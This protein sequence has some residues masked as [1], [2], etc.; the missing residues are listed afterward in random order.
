MTFI[1]SP[2]AIQKD[3]KYPEELKEQCGSL[4]IPIVGNAANH[5]DSTGGWF[6]LSGEPSAPKIVKYG[7]PMEGGMSMS[8]AMPFVM[9]TLSMNSMGGDTMISS[10][11]PKATASSSPISS[12]AASIVSDVHVIIYLVQFF[13]MYYLWS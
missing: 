13:F 12:S 5:T 8:G 6:N 7:M 9:P 2:A 10:T 3:L 4:N 1:E 11:M